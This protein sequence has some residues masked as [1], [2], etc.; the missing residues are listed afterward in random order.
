[1]LVF[2]F[3][4]W[5]IIDGVNPFHDGGMHGFL[6]LLVGWVFRVLMR[7]GNA[8]STAFLDAVAQYY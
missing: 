3:W 5:E 2:V 8:V 1:M 6:D 4:H 7:S